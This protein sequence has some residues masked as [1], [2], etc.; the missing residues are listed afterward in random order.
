M[1]MIVTVIWFFL[2][3]PCKLVHISLCS[4]KTAI[5]MLKILGAAVQNLVTW[6]TRCLGFMHPGTRI[7]FWWSHL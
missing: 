5:I 4:E 1:M 7:C 6:V 2:L 3:R